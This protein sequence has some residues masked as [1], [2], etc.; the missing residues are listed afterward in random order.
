MKNRRMRLMAIFA[1]GAGVGATVGA[2]G[3]MSKRNTILQSAKLLVAVRE[4]FLNDEHDLEYS[5]SIY[6][7]YVE[8][9]SEIE[10]KQAD[11]RVRAADLTGDEKKKALEEIEALEKSAKA[12]KIARSSLKSFISAYKVGMSKA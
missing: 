9:I 3:L 12:M 6:E 8:N 7:Q 11:M 10:K 5:N 4:I 1:A 2:A